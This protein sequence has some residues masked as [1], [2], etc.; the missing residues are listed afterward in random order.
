MEINFIERGLGEREKDLIF[1]PLEASDG[2]FHEFDRDETMASL[3]VKAGLFP[4]IRQAKSNGWNRPVDCG[5]NEYFIGKF[6][7]RVNVWLPCRCKK[8]DCGRNKQ[9]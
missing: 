1:G 5:Y 7:N 2:P 4:S 8:H 3:M 6:K 9:G